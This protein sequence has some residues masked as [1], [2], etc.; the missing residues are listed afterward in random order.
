MFVKQEVQREDHVDD[1]GWFCSSAVQRS[2]DHYQMP[3]DFLGGS[4]T[5]YLLHLTVSK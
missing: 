2:P 4:R 5:T 3:S 1:S